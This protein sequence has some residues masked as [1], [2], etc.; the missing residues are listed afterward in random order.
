M[1]TSVSK[2]TAIFFCAVFAL[3][4]LTYITLGD[5]FLTTGEDQHTVLIPPA[6][7]PEGALQYQAVVEK[8]AVESGTL[9]VGP[10]C[11][12]SP[13]VLKLREGNTLAVHN[14]DTVDHTIAFEDQ[15]FFAVSAQQTRTIDLKTVLSRVAGTYRYRCSDIA[16]STNVGVVYVVQ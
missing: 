12:M 3:T 14:G 8:L 2:K 4:L 5:K 6:P 16:S 1:R 9:E 15:N 7:T 13:L 11:A 10:A